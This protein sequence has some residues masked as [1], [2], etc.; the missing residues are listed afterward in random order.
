MTAV[1]SLD[2]AGPRRQHNYEC[3]Y[4]PRPQNPNGLSIPSRLSQISPSEIQE[5][6][7]LFEPIIDTRDKIVTHRTILVLTNQRKWTIFLRSSML[8]RLFA[9]AFPFLL[10]SISYS[11]MEESLWQAGQGYVCAST[12]TA[13]G[14]QTTAG[15]T[16]TPTSTVIVFNPPTS[17]KNYVVQDAGY[18]FTASPAAAADVVLAFN[19]AKTTPSLAGTTPGNFTTQ[20][21]GLSTSTLITNS[22]AGCYIAAQLPAIPSL[23]RVLGGSTGAL[24]ISPMQAVDHL[25]PYDVIIPPGGIVSFQTSSAVN[26]CA[27]LSWTEVPL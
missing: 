3:Y 9:L 26:L 10:P 6:T 21:V 20:A 25:Q 14:V 23:F 16:A 2:P 1:G 4:P 15:L 24:S 13:T 8:R 19:V 18:I 27:H 11:M 17:G 7:F 12:A 5:P 22:V